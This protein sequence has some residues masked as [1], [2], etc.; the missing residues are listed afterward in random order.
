MEEIEKEKE[1]KGKRASNTTTRTQFIFYSRN[2]TRSQFVFFSFIGNAI[3]SRRTETRW[4]CHRK[5]NKQT[6]SYLP[7]AIN[8]EKK[9]KKSDIQK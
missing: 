1:R 5:R 6:K 2:R 3:N 4:R 7:L 9:N 8:R